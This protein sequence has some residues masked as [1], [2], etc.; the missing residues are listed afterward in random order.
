VGKLAGHAFISYVREDSDAVDGLQQTLEAAGV[1]VWRDTADL[2]PG[3][4]WRA[5]IRDAITRDALVFI[6]CFSSRGA[7]RLKSYQNEELVLAIEQLR[8]RRPDVPWLI[9]VRLDDCRIPDLDIGAGRSLGSI[10]HADLF[11][12]RSAESTSRLVT[13][14]LRILGPSLAEAK[15]AAGRSRSFTELERSIRSESPSGRETVNRLVLLRQL[16]DRTELA[17]LEHGTLVEHFANQTGH[18]SLVGNAYLGRVQNL[19]PSMETAF[20]DIGT[21]RN[22]VLFTGEVSSGPSD[23]QG[24]GRHIESELKAGQ[25]VVV[26][27]IKDPVGNQGARLTSQISVPGRYLVYV[28]GMAMAGIS[29]KLPDTERARLESILQKIK[30]ENAG[31]I[32]RAAAENVTEEELSREVARL[33]AQWQSIDLK[34]KSA[35]P[36]EL[37]YDEPDLTIR[38]AR[39]ILDED[40]TR[41]I[42]SGDRSWDAVD[43]YVRYVAPYLIDRLEHWTSDAD[44]FAGYRVGEQLATTLERRVK[45]PSGGSLAIDNTEAMTVVHVSNGRFTGQPGRL[46]ETVI[47]NNLEAAE[48][49][50]RQLRLRDIDG[51]I[52]IDFTDMAFES[53]REP[54]VRRLIE[55]L[56]RD[57]AQSRM[58]ELTSLGLVQVTRKRVGFNQPASA[59]W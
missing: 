14:V 12:E 59:S 2:W 41:L 9:P 5:R 37:L 11:G 27:V 31:V 8:M 56:S 3:E 42:V 35:R 43:E 15:A 40:V 51:K 17:I 39:D 18:R 20:V 32:A 54:V 49:V 48:E 45:L 22:A 52:I 55:C 25:P 58:I 50:A 46:D 7:A 38:V 44:I 13:T 19:L 1:P 21:D 24:P 34:A 6:A 53:S 28:P 57:R 23:S 47:R 4:D 29:R 30:P 16:A 26:Q 10:Q 36:P 33:S